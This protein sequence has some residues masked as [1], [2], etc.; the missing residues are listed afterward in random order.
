MANANI[1]AD[2]MVA[3]IPDSLLMTTQDA[4]NDSPTCKKVQEKGL[5]NQLK[6]F[7]VTLPLM[8]GGR[9][10]E[11]YSISLLVEG[12]FFYAYKSV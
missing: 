5:L 7:A 12:E 1:H 2:S 10:E 4:L 9:K 8:K 3:F 6:S 11:D